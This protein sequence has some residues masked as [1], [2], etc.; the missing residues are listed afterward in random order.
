MKKKKEI[1]E[2]GVWVTCPSCGTEYLESKAW[3]LE[4]GIS[5]C[6]ICGAKLGIL[7]K[8]VVFD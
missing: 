3:I 5:E 6:P 2:R 1:I 8:G 4:D 7:T